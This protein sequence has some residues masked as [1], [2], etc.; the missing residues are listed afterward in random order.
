M[1]DAIQKFKPL[2]TVKGHR[3]FAGMVNSLIWFVQN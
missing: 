2:T 1:L 3:S